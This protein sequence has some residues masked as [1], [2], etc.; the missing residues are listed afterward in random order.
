[1]ILGAREFGVRRY[2]VQEGVDSWNQRKSEVVVS[3]PL[4]LEVEIDIETYGGP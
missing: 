1:V 4:D 3:D 2:R